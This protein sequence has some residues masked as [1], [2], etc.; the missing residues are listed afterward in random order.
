M[1]KLLFYLL[2]FSLV[3]VAYK[4]LSKVFF[5]ITNGEKITSFY[6]FSGIFLSIGLSAI[7]IWFGVSFLVWIFWNQLLPYF[8]NNRIPKISFFQSIG[9]VFGLR[10]LDGLLGGNLG[11]LANIF[12]G[13]FAL[14]YSLKDVS[15]AISSRTTQNSLSN[16]PNY[17][18]RNLLPSVNHNQVKNITPALSSEQIICS[19]CNIVNPCDSKFCG[20]C[21]EK[22]NSNE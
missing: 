16:P 20:N 1:G 10:F 9:I 17:K 22:V 14:R 6:F 3:G 12:G 18:K 19:N 15:Y 8:S 7:V 13:G 21:G 2:I 4:I 11:R 5:A